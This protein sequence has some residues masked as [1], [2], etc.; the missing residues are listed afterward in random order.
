[1]PIFDKSKIKASFNQANQTYNSNAILQKIVAKNLVEMAKQDIYNAKNILDLGAGTGFVAEEILSEF[2]S[3][4]ILQNFF[5]LDIALQMLIRN[6]IATSKIVGD[7]EF[8]PLAENIFD[9]AFSSLSF[10]WLNDLEK[11]LFQVLKTLKK[12]GN[13]YFSI[14][15]SQSLQ[16]LRDVCRGCQINLSINNF[17]NQDELEKI[18]NNLNLNYQIQSTTTSFEYQ[19]LYFLLKSIKSIGAGYS[20]NKNYLGKK[21]FELLN[22]FY[23]KNFNLNNKV[24]ATWQVFYIKIKYV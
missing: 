12:N 2:N 14:I 1:M 17:L 22:N 23:L 20:F 13:F 21:Q 11:S 16:E 7:I 9:L 18:L 19:N 6:Q 8:L 15:G 4:I 24:F 5:Q 10:Q 3:E